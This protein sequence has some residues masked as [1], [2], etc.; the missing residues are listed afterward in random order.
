MDELKYILAAPNQ[1]IIK[2]TLRNAA[3]KANPLIGVALDIS[4][5]TFQLERQ[6]IE[7]AIIVAGK[8]IGFGRRKQMAL[9]RPKQSPLEAP[10]LWWKYAYALIAGTLPSAISQVICLKKQKQRG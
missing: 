8:L 3:D 5:L 2:I 4:S 6:Q 7:Q 9:A 1:Q 10:R